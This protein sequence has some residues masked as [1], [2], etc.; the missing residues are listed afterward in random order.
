MDPHAVC[1]FGAPSSGVTSILQVL[2]DASDENIAIVAPGDVKILDAVER[3]YRDGA[4]HV[5]VDGA[6]HSAAAVQDI[7]DSRLVWPGHGAI[8]RVH[9]EKPF[10]PA[11]EGGWRLF[12]NEL[13]DIE[14][15][16]RLLSAPYFTV[17]NTKGD[18]GLGAAVAELARRAGIRK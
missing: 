6:P 13:P 7:V 9:A 12:S 5:F 1:V 18:E 3:A 15:R 16:I 4:K 14:R 2:A 10:G 8:V 17:Q 11:T